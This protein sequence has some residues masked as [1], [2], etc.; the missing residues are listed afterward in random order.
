MIDIH[1][2][3]LPEVDDGAVSWDVAVSMCRMAAQD[4]IQHMVATPHANDQFVYRRQTLRQKLD[5]LRGRVGEVPALS[6]G[7]DFHLSFDNL[8]S[9]AA[10]PNDYTIEDTSYLLIE[11]SEYSVPPSV[12]DQLAGLLRAGLRPII[13]HP[14][15]NILLQGRP[16]QVL[17]WVHLGCAVQVTASALTGR[18]GRGPRKFAE[19]LLQWGAVHLLATDSHSVRGRPPILSQARDKVSDMRG[20]AIAKALVEDNPQAV[21]AGQDL[22]Y[23]PR[24]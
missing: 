14:E 20:E 19:A 2:H 15:R 5:E 9:L 17:E 13:T 3:I 8:E 4:G 21:I 12:T 11:L 16:Q 24:I 10:E 6:L 18:W 7:C 1:S 22:P 23:F